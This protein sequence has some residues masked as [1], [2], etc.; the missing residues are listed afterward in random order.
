MQA[1]GGADE[2]TSGGFEHGGGQG[3]YFDEAAGRHVDE[4]MQRAGGLLLVRRTYEIFAG[5]WPTA[6]EDR[7]TADVLNSLPK[8]VASTT[9]EEPL[10]WSNSHL[11][12]GDVAAEVA[13]LKQQDG[14][15]LLVFGSGGRV[16]T[17]MRHDLVDEYRLQVNP[18]VLGS[19]KRLFDADTRVPL[20]F[21]DTKVST[22]GVLLLTYARG[23]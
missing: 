13:A 9:L 1:P 8:Y 10:E 12:K 18:I 3:P 21:V 7:E 2:D 11:L 5:Y 23:R 19:G 6:T 15:D 4:A 22:T 14:K 20:S 17:L 16:H